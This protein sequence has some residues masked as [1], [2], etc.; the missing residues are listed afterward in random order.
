[1]VLDLGT[2]DGR[3]V[4]ARAREEPAALVIGIDASAAG[5]AESSFRADRPLQKGGTP[6]AIF[7][8]GAAERPIDELRGR[9][10]ELTIVMPWGSCA[11][12]WPSATPP[13]RP[14][15]SPRSS[16][17]AVACGFSCRLPH[18]TT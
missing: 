4:V 1:V 18:A 13:T 7:A 8:V 2:G 11:V 12:R 16:R 6:N 14:P 3:A 10:D 5:M 15:G 9:A 17:R